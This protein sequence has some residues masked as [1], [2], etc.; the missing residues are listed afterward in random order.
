MSMP[1][2][3]WSPFSETEARVIRLLL[4]SPPLSRD[5]IARALDESPDGR[6][7]GIMAT[8]VARDVVLV[9]SEGYSLNC[10]EEKKAGVRAWLDARFPVKGNSPPSGGAVSA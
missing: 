6:L 5:Q 4:D 1:V 3:E 8:L 7:K 2:E 9:K 10:S